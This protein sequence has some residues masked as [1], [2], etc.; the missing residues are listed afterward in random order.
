M[1]FDANFPRIDKT[2]QQADFEINNLGASGRQITVEYRLD[3]GSWTSLGTLNS[4]SSNQTLNFADGVD[5]KILEL[6]FKPTQDSEDTDNAPEI[7][8][9]RVVCQLRPSRIQLLPLQLYLADNIT[10]LNGA[11]EGKVKGDLAQLRTWAGQAD[12]VIVVDSEE[13]TRDMV[14]LPGSVRVEE[15]G[16]EYGR[17]SEFVVTLTLAEVE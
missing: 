17:R 11:T 13:V 10:K 8:Q 12:E 5:G 2:F 6:R 9:F 1:E 7:L 4:T 14:V 16:H 3:K 15:V